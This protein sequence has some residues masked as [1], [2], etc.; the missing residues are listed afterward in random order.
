[1]LTKAAKAPRLYQIIPGVHGGRMRS[2]RNKPER[3]NALGYQL[4]TTPRGEKGIPAAKIEEH[5][6]VFFYTSNV[7]DNRPVIYDL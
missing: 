5:R 6:S 2:H 1:M 3:T 7:Y 4:V